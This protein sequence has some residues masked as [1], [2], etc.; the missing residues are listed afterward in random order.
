MKLVEINKARAAIA[1]QIE[2]EAERDGAA[3]RKSN[4]FRIR[5]SQRRRD[6]RNRVSPRPA[7]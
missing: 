6:S 2:A 1:A 5:P 4:T 3:I 7:A